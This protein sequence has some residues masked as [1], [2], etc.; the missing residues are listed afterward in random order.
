MDI[1]LYDKCYQSESLVAIII[2][3][4]YPKIMKLPF[5]EIAIELPECLVDYYYL[6]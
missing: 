1:D 2:T 6:L 5:E 4:N 3:K